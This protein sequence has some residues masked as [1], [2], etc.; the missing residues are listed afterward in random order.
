M[1]GMPPPP[2]PLFVLADLRYGQQLRVGNSFSTVIAEF[3]F[4]TFSPAGFEWDESAGKYRAPLGA[5]RKG[6]PAVGAARY[7]EHPDA[8]VLTLSYDLKDGRG[9]RRWQPGELYPIDLFQHLAEGKLIEAHNVSFERWIWDK[10][11]VPKYRWPELPVAQLRCNMA[12]SRAHALPG[13]LSTLGDALHLSQVKDTRG[14]SLIKKFTHPRDPTKTKPA[15]RVLPTDEPEEFEA[16]QAYCDQDVRTEAEASSRVP[17][18]SPVE[19]RYWQMDQAINRRGMAVDI[20]SVDACLDV[21]RQA[22]PKYNLRLSQITGGAVTEASKVEALKTWL[23]ARG[24]KVGKSLDEEAIEDLLKGLEPDCV[25]REALEIRL[26]IGSAAVKKIYALSRRVASD[27][28]LHDMYTYYGGRTGRASGAGEDGPGVQGQNLPNSGPEVFRCGDAG[29]GKHFGTHL[30]EC[31]WCNASSAFADTKEWNPAAVEEAL[32]VVRSRCLEAVEY[33]YGNAIKVISGSLRGLLIAA[34]GKRLICSDFSSI[35]GVVTAFVAGEEWMMEVYRTHGKIYEAT[36]SQITGIPF[37]EFM[38]VAGYTDLT[39]PQWWLDKMTGHHHPMRKKIGKPGALGS[40]FGGWIGAWKRFGADEFLTDAEIKD[41]LKK[42]RAASPNIVEMWG[43]QFRG[44]PWDDNRRP[45]LYGLEGMCVAAILNPGQEFSYRQ[46][47]YFVKDDV[48]YCRLPSGRTLDYHEP[49]LYTS[50]RQTGGYAI[51][52]LGFNSNPT[53]G[54][55]GWV[56]ME[57]YGGICFQNSVQAIARDIMFNG[58]LNLEEHGYPIVLHTHDEPCAEVDEGFGTVVEFER[59]LT[60][61]SCLPW[62]VGWPIKAAGGWS[63]KRYRKD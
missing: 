27:G 25:E 12:K 15:H 63:G 40:G 32:E 23:K 21:L 14:A 61:T 36:A 41:G 33:F 58:M 49:R 42:W 43:G 10:V 39:K 7:A 60:D 34:K 48:L 20:E 56:R 30:D 1:T 54:A 2:P 59:L 44:L 45:E 3:D 62:C 18:L 46:V 53:K 19:L 28:R 57:L 9:V 22:Y 38:R 16:F 31:P 8:E 35:E 5:T 29:C 55:L 13:K 47:T 50:D 6:L 51:S 17:D 4:E 11:C 37:E 26:M 52:F 24:V